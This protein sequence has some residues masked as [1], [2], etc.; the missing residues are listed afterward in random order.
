M[1]PFTLIIEHDHLV[2]SLVHPLSRHEETLLRA[3]LPVASEV[4]AVDPHEPF[5]PATH[6]DVRV[7]DLL[8]GEAAAIKYRSRFGCRGEFQFGK[9]GEWKRKDFPTT[10]ILIVQ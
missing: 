5:A 3:N 1:L 6:I 2:P 9:I 10:Q 4:M 7:S 8:Q